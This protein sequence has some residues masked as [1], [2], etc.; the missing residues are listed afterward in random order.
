VNIFAHE[1]LTGVLSV[2]QS[3]SQNVTADD[4]PDALLRAWFPLISWISIGVFPRCFSLICCL[5][6]GAPQALFATQVWADLIQPDHL[7]HG[8]LWAFIIAKIES[9][10]NTVLVP[11]GKNEVP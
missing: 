2:F 4:P 11:L 9:V 8:T 10:F 6:Q 7:D 3:S 5:A 1:A